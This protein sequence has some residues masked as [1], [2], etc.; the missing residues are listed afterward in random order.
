MVFR[1]ESRPLSQESLRVHIN[2]FRQW[3]G[4]NLGLFYVLVG[5]LQKGATQSLPYYGT[6]RT[7]ILDFPSE[8]LHF[9]SDSPRF[10]T[11]IGS[12]AHVLGIP[13]GGKVR[14]EVFARQSNTL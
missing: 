13:S 14:E 12:F 10:Q 9:G 3:G 7:A 8:R 4:K 2:T 1:E 6:L 11:M 5:G